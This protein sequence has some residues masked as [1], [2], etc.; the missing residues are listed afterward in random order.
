MRA[1][2][3]IIG[4]TFVCFVC[5]FIRP[6][7]AFAALSSTPNQNTWVTN[8]LVRTIVAS[9]DG[10]TVYLG[11]LFT[12]VGP[13]TGSGVPYATDTGLKKTTFPKVNGDIYAVV[14]DGSGGWYVGGDFTSV[15]GTTR[16]RIAHI[17]ADSTL[18]SS[19]NPNADDY[20]SILSLSGTTL[21]VGGSF[22]T[23]GGA[24]RNNIAAIDTASG[25]AT[26]FDPNA[27][28]DVYTFALSGTT[29]YVGG[30]FNT[31]GNWGHSYFAEFDEPS[32][33]T[34]PSQ[35]LITLPNTGSSLLILVS[36]ILLS[37]GFGTKRYYLYL[38]DRLI[39]EVRSFLREKRK[40]KPN[41][42]W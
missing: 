6:S 32:T 33:Q 21:Y 37:V 22:H 7:T 15:E 31:I 18:D 38:R 12:H 36:F 23:I 27:D 9:F 28:S 25:N 17:N 34:P 10:S 26:S 8:G 5:F 13:Y 42:F 2:H 30:W 1:V 11:G 29:L 14:A 35:R 39:L 19:F 24:S 3:V 41:E 20:V 40:S 4:I 16:N